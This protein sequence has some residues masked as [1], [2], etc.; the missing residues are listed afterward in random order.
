V[1]GHNWQLAASWNAWGREY[2]A[3]PRR[4]EFVA[5]AFTVFH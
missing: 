1:R 5:V 3:Q 4:A 2:T